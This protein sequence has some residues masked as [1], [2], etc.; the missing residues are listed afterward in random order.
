MFW[1]S[2]VEGFRLLRH[3]EIRIGALGV[4]A[5]FLLTL[6]MVGK[7]AKS[8][9]AGCAGVLAIVL[10]MVL[11]PSIFTAFFY[12]F[13]LPI[14]LGRSSISP[15]DAVVAHIWPITQAGLTAAG[16]GL[17]I[18]LV[19]FIMRPQGRV[20]GVRAGRDHHADAHG[21][22]VLMYLHTCS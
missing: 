5:V 22:P 21:L 9:R 7:L 8:T 3:P 1:T 15:L 19:P 16:V 6:F 12:A 4:T 10:G 13:L 17:L 14:I 20:L 11:L 2:I 18:F